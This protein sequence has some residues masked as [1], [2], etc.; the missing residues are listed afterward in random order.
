MVDDVPE[1]GK[2][3]KKKPSTLGIRCVS[4]YIRTRVDYCTRV[5]S[6]GL[7]L[8]LTSVSGKDSGPLPFR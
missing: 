6:L 7:S 4:K 5:Q 1:V 2:T 8:R 3:K